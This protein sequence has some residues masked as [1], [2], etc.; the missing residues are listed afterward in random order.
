MSRKEDI[1][2]S[3]AELLSLQ[4]KYFPAQCKNL[5]KAC[6]EGIKQMKETY[7]AVYKNGMWDLYYSKKLKKLIGPL[8]KLLS[9][10]GSSKDLLRTCGDQWG[11]MRLVLSIPPSIKTVSKFDLLINELS[12]N[13]DMIRYALL[14]SNHMEFQRHENKLSYVLGMRSNPKF[15]QRIMTTLSFVTGQASPS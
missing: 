6:S 9:T 2:K 10:L 3:L 15:L 11:R 1:E 13:L 7:D 12:W 5:V 8:D 4:V 14:L